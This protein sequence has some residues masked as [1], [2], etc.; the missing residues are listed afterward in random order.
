MGLGV[1]YARE[2]PIWQ[3]QNEPTKSV[4]AFEEEFLL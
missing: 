2:L 3:P 4:D 1:L